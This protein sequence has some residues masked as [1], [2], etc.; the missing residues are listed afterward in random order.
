MGEQH[1]CS[2]YNIFCCSSSS[3]TKA[4]TDPKASCS[5]S[6][7]T[8]TNSGSCTCTCTC[9]CTNYSKANSARASSCGAHPGCKKEF[10]L[11]SSRV[12][13]TCLESHF[14]QLDCEQVCKPCLNNFLLCSTTGGSSG[15]EP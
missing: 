15:G 6:S 13:C 4:S 1:Y 11:W 12:V 5:T 7:K 14:A 10:N 3:S 9:S 8:D 2:T